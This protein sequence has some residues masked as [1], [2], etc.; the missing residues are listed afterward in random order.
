MSTYAGIG[1]RATPPEILDLMTRIARYLSTQG[2]TLRSGGAKGADSA[3]ERGATRKEIFYAKDAKNHPGALAT[4][5]Q[6]HPAPQALSEYVRLLMARN[7][8]QVLGKNLNDPVDFVIC[9]TP[10][11]ATSSTT[12]RTGGTGQAIRIAAAHNIRVL[13]LA[14]TATRVAVEKRINQ[15]A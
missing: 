15:E 10:D 8:F 1:A 7:A 3:F 9:W 14:N 12:R 13:N 2:Y 11:G 5:A 4:V 6:F